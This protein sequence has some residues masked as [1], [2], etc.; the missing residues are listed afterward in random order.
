MFSLVLAGLSG[1]LLGSIP[2]AYLLVQW[3]S[4]VD[5][6]QTGSGNVGTLN[7]YLVTR[8]K[9]VGGAVFLGDLLKGLAAVWLARVSFGGQFDT[10]AMAAAAA[11]LGHNY[12]VWLH[13]RG[14]RGLATGAGA[15]VFVAPLVI[16]LWGLLWVG[17]FQILRKVN[18]A[19]ALASIVAALLLLLAPGQGLTPLFMSDAETWQYKIFAL[20]FFS[21]I[22]SR[23]REPVVE[24]LRDRRNKK[25]GGTA[26]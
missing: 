12:P 13:F 14:G 26:K 4:K 5:I 3:F 22:L 10:S 20:I 21:I 2:T 7:S 6:R 15:L 18:V 8:S 23:H 25:E 16:A 11:V 19:N 24:F 9:M 17:G 1:Y